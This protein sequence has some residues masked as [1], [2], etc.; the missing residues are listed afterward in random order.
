MRSSI[1]SFEARASRFR[2]SAPLRNHERSLHL[3]E[4]LAETSLDGLYK[5]RSRAKRRVPFGNRTNK[6][7][8]LRE[9]LLKIWTILY[10]W[11]LQAI[12]REL[13][14]YDN[15][16]VLLSIRELGFH[17]QNPRPFRYHNKQDCSDLRIASLPLGNALQAPL[18]ASSELVAMMSIRA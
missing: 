17:Q 9:P 2:S 4:I 18:E 7:A 14:R 15:L 6:D 8:M 11:P 5:T 12:V 13:S 3:A 10:I 16:A 1:M